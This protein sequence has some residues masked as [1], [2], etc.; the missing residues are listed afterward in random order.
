M[1]SKILQRVFAIEVLLTLACLTGC[2]DM[3]K[4]PLLDKDSGESVPVLLI[5][6]NFIKTKIDLSLVDLETGAEINQ[7]TVVIRFMGADSIS[8][9]NFYGQRKSTFSTSSSFVEVGVDP[10]RPIDIQNPINLTVF[11]ASTHYISAPQSITYSSEGYKILEIQMIKKT[12]MKSGA[13]LGFDEPFTMLADGLPIEPAGGKLQFIEDIRRL[14]TGNAFDYLNFYFASISHSQLENPSAAIS[15]IN[16]NDPL[17][18]SDYGVYYITEN[19]YD[20]VVPPR[21]PVKDCTIYPGS[22]V[23]TTVR[24]T[25]TVKCNEGLSIRVLGANGQ[26]GSGTFKYRITTDDGRRKEG[27]FYCNFPSDFLVE[28]IYYPS[29][30]LGARLELFG[31]EQWEPSAAINVKPFCGAVVK[32]TVTK[33]PLLIPFI[34]VTKFNCPNDTYAYALSLTG[35]FR[36]SG[37]PDTAPWT[38][39]T[40]NQ[41]VYMLQL[42]PGPDYDIRIVLDNKTYYYTLPTDEA[43]I[44]LIPR[45]NASLG[46][47][48]TRLQMNKSETYVRT[49]LDILFTQAICDILR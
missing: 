40:A 11:A 17:I 4:N 43:R 19:S 48:I 31:D 33:K 21:A 23:Y 1:K 34:F 47:K 36:K 26:T 9:I 29:Y 42:E 10:N 27:L 6:R 5:D 25:A 28:N 8:L 22:N 37:S 14:P 24:K 2:E 18:Y 15:C 49:E 3:F 38:P 44:N 20:A 39:F 12:S 16:L 46:Y 13:A 41:G 30:N 32:F 7:D 45:E 35:A